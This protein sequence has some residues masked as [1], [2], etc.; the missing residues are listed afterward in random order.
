M[1][2]NAR[3]KNGRERTNALVMFMC[4]THVTYHSLCWE[5]SNT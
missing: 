5:V 4:T 3:A 2:V 1:F